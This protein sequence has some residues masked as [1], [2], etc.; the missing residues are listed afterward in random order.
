MPISIRTLAPTIATASYRFAADHEVV[1]ED[2]PWIHARTDDGRLCGNCSRLNFPWLFKHPL[3]AHKVSDGARTAQLSDGICLGLYADISSRSTC[4]FCQLL[5][6]ALEE[7]ADIE[8]MNQ[9]DAWPQQ[10]VWINNHFLSETGFVMIPE[11]ETDEVIARLGV[12]LKADDEEDVIISFKGRTTMIQEIV[13]PSRNPANGAG[14]AV[15][16][17]VEDLVETIG[18]WLKPC[19]TQQAPP[20]AMSKRGE[21]A[22]RLIDTEKY[23]IVGPF[24]KQRYVALR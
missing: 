4:N 18:G 8:L 15:D 22:I 5:V 7:G 6:H 23:C 3:S 12:R 10:E 14:R 9:Y 20:A 21:S 11:S 13:E 24:C 17:N 2:F 16:T 1:E 19:L